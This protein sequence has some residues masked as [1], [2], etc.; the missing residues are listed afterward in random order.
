MTTSLRRRTACI[1]AALLAA[2]PCARAAAAPRSCIAPDALMDS[3]AQRHA[4]PA[5]D[6]DDQRFILPRERSGFAT[7]DHIGA[8]S[9]KDALTERRWFKSGSGTLISACYVLTSY[10]VVFPDFAQFNTQRRVAFSFG[11]SKLDG[12]P[13]K[14]AAEGVP[15]DI[16]LFNP[17]RPVYALDQVLIRLKQRAPA[18][19]AKLEFA[20]V[21][22]KDFG[23]A[24]VYA[25][26]YPG[27]LDIFT[28][29][30]APLLCDRCQVK[31]YHYLRGY[32]TNCT[33]PAGTSGGAV[34]R[35]LKDKN[36]D[37]Q[38]KLALVGAPNQAPEVEVFPKNHPRIRSFVSDYNK[39]A[40]AIKRIVDRDDC[41]PLA[42]LQAQ[43]PPTYGY[44]PNKLW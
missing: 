20:D 14:Y 36:C 18:E 42:E 15:V 39:A 19:Y 27:D 6:R 12:T 38:L 5:A 32:E 1:A 26:G 44:S 23:A 9:I 25:C 28:G 30:P 4:K 7:F 41:A 16:G 17:Q 22:V 31:G 34:L 29:D 13:F 43:S 24:E 10:H 2:L 3:S 37:P 33:M 40:A 35:A 21:D 8:V 11:V